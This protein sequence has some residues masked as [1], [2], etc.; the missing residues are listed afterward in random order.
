[1]CGS[2]YSQIR[3]IWRVEI[4]F[5]GDLFTWAC[6]LVSI[7]IILDETI[8]QKRIHILVLIGVGSLLS[9]SHPLLRCIGA[10]FPFEVAIGTNGRVWFKAPEIKH[11]ACLARAIEWADEQEE[12][13]SESSV[14]KW[15]DA[16]VDA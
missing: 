14:R 1:M 2:Y 8:C 6:S 15:I 3:R 7:I 13:L 5:H 16:N 4:G 11:T 12:R 9:N 10:R